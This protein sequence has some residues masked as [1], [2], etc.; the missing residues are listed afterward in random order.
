LEIPEEELV[1]QPET[2]EIA[3]NLEEDLLYEEPE[4]EEPLSEEIIGDDALP[5]IQVEGFGDDL[6]NE[7]SESSDYTALSQEASFSD[8]PENLKSEIRSVLS[9]MDQLLESLPE[10]KIQ[11]FARSD[12]FDTYKKL[13]EELGL[14]V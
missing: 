1:L 11:E 8:I 14:K 9:Y 2:E 7:V 4:Q 13:F 3:E 12:H 5:D 6:D 10:E